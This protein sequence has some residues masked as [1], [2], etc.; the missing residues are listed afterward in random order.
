[1]NHNLAYRA[2]ACRNFHFLPGMR[3]FDT[4]TGEFFRVQAPDERAG[5]GAEES[6]R[7][8]LIDGSDPATIGCLLSLVRE[9]F[10][11]SILVSGHEDQWVIVRAKFIDE[12]PRG[13][14]GLTIGRIDGNSEFEVLVL[15]LEQLNE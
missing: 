2:R 1:M 10:G 3:V 13:M 15:A 11:E 14:T 4:E 7:D 8:L 9:G 5:K 6:N 12:G